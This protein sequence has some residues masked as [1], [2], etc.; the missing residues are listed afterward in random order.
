MKLSNKMYDVLK[1]IALVALNAA[2][3]CYKTLSLIWALPYGE[4][5]MATC[6]ALALCIGALI[7]VSTA[8]YQADKAA[9]AEYS[10]KMM[11]YQN[12]ELRS[13]AYP[14]EEE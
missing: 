9:D 12:N 14:D 2:G 13:I 1:W 3:V 7:G 10:Y 4:E 5:V 8:Q 11:L 6:A